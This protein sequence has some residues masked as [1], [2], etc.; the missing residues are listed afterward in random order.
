MVLMAKLSEFFIKSKG[1]KG[2]DGKLVAQA[3][4]NRNFLKTGQLAVSLV[5]VAGV[6]LKK[7]RVIHFR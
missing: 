7:N 4:G 5:V 6:S 2:N 1:D 3:P